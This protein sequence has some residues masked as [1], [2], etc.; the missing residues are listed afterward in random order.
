MRRLYLIILLGL[1]VIFTN[2][3]SSHIPAERDM[4]RGSIASG[5]ADISSARAAFR[6]PVHPAVARVPAVS[7][8]DPDDILLYIR[9]QCHVTGVNYNFALSLLREENISFFRL[10]DEILPQEWVFEVRSRND[11]GSV[12]YGLWQLNGNFLWI[13]YI[14]NYWHG[15]TEFNWENPYHNTYIAVR[16]IKW[17]Y[18][19]LQKHNVEKGTPQP[20][21][22]LYWETAMAYNAGLDRVRGGSAPL[23]TLDYAIRVFER[24]NL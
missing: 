4:P 16:H 7:E 6:Q 9:E 14:P 5:A 21:N 18:T 12:D 2:S 17:L 15:L 3:N 24:L 20:V 19:S 22:S 11:N 23:T 13:N 10:F 1:V 8:F